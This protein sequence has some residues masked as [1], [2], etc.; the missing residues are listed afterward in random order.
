MT[1]ENQN[2]NSKNNAYLA[3]NVEAIHLVEQLHQC[4]LNFTVRG[5]TL[6]YKRISLKFYIFFKNQS[7]LRLQ[8]FGKSSSSNSVDF[9]HKD[10]AWLVL[11]GIAKHLADHARTLTNV[12]VDN[13]ARDNLKGKSRNEKITHLQ[14]ICI[15]IRCHRTSKQRLSSA[16]RSVQETALRRLRVKIR[17][18]KIYRNSDTLKELWIS[19]RELNDLTQLSNLFVQAT[20]LVVRNVARV[21]M[22][23]VVHEGINLNI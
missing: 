4:T 9:I 12:L 16:R 2:N 5:C 21:F 3:Q 17:T 14:E 11:S 20:N 22:R 23:H 10:N 6:K 13:G 1:Y 7:H 15:N 18:A 8:T 19:E